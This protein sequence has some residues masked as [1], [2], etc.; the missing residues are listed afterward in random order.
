MATTIEESAVTGLP[1]LVN[2]P[3]TFINAGTAQAGAMNAT[4]RQITKSAL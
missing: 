4:N 3:C 1:P 2:L